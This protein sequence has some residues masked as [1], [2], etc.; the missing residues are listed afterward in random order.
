[1]LVVVARDVAARGEVQAVAG[2]ELVVEVST[3]V[4]VVRAMAVVAMTMAVA[5]SS[6]GDEGAGAGGEGAGSCGEDTG[7]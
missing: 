7:K 2:R 5:G 1:M 6:G 4:Q 3:E